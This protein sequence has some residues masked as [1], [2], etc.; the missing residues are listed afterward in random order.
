M[1]TKQLLFALMIETSL[2]MLTTILLIQPK[3]VFDGQSNKIRDTARVGGMFLLC[4]T[5]CWSVVVG[6]VM[7]LN[8]MT[9][10]L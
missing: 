6:C 8:S 7:A 3:F 10:Q 4:I 5:F 1:L 9:I 2:V